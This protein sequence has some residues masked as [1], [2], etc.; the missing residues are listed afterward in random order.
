MSRVEINNLENEKMKEMN[1]ESKGLFS[2]SNAS[3]SLKA[4][5]NVKINVGR[6]NWESIFI[7]KIIIIKNIK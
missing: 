5:R 6:R 1:W 4:V 2:V 3:L 7:S